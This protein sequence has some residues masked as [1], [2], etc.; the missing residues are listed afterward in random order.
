[1]SV[2]GRIC[3]AVDFSEPSRLALSEAARL[4][5]DDGA[6]LTVLHVR[7]APRPAPE[8]LYAPPLAWQ[9]ESTPA[10]LEE[11]RTEAERIR[12]G[13]VDSVL[14]GQPVAPAITAFARETGVDLIVLS[15]HGR[16]GLARVVVGSVAEAVVRTAPCPVLVVRAPA[17]RGKEAEDIPVSFPP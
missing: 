8:V 12:E 7:E 2:Y 9:D 6:S 13:P 14:L 4:A 16:T 15:S 10:E 11:W 17:I 3:C 1:M 5:R